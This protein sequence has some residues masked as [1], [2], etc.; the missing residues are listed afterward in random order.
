MSEYITELIFR[1]GRKTQD[2]S[3][4]RSYFKACL[5]FS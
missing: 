4:D 5:I 3:T 2:D 1:Y